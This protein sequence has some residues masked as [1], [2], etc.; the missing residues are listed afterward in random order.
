MGTRPWRHAVLRHHIIT[1]SSSLMRGGATR[2]PVSL[3]C[4]ESMIV[5]VQGR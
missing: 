3:L 4:L 1:Q 2:E 5:L